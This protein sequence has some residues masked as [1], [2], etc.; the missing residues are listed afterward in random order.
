MTHSTLP[1]GARLVNEFNGETF[2]F[3]HGAD[4][5]N[6]AE[7]DVVLE[8]GGSGGADALEHIHPLADEH[9]TVHSGAIL[10]SIKGVQHTVLA[11]D[12][13]VVPRG[14]PHFFKNAVDGVTEI[15]IRFTPAGQQLRFFANF[16]FLAAHRKQW[17]SKK[18]VPHFLL[19]ALVLATYKDCLYLAGSPIF[20]QKLLFASLAPIARLMGYRIEIKPFPETQHAEMPVSVKL[21]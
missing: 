6:N 2:V 7:F 15:T 1:R 12:E 18:G 10:V 21:T 13:V 9:F 19:M 11:G 8:P 16:S 5:P 3:R 17:F 20:L 14:M 4:D